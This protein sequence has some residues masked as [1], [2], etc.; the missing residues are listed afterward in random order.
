MLHPNDL[1]VTQHQQEMQRAAR[2]HQLVQAAQSNHKPRLNAATQTLWTTF[3]Q[4]ILR[5]PA[6]PR[7]NTRHAR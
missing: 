6:V 7:L 1:I 2:Q 4:Q 5:R 3:S